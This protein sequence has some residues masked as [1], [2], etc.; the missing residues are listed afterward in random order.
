[1]FILFTVASECEK[2]APHHPPFRFRICL[3]KEKIQKRSPFS[4]PFLSSTPLHHQTP[5]W[6]IRLL[7]YI[8]D[9]GIQGVT[10]RCRLSVLTNS[11][12]VFEPKR[13]G[14]RKL[15]GHSQWVQLYTGDQI[16]FGDLTPYFKFQCFGSTFFG[17][18]GSGS[19]SQ[20]YGSRSGSFNH[21]AKIVRK[22]LISSVLCLHLDSLSLKNDVNVP[23]KSNEQKSFF[24]CYL[25][26][27]WRSM[28]KIAGSGSGSISQMHGS[29][30]PDPHQIVM[31]SE[32]WV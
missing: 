8:L 26:A 1:M 7:P 17:S 19:T 2:D 30:D 5:P 21:Q 11:A 22:T 3:K 28:T 32:H 9:T 15:R 16:N 6:P 20:R 27:S 10:K 23:S 25:L 24:V 12:L 13:G 4:P 18:P 29:S 14:G 31:D